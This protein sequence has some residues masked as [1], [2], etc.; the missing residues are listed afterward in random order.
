MKLRCGMSAARAVTLAVT[1]KFITQRLF[2]DG[3]LND[4]ERVSISLCLSANMNKC[5]PFLRE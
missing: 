2:R 5:S 3:L 1:H 4:N